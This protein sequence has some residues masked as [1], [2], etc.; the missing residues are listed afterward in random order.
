MN[1]YFFFCYDILAKLGNQLVPRSFT[2][3]ARCDENGDI[4]VGITFAYFIQ[5]KR[6][7]DL[8]GN[9]TRMV[10]GD[11]HYIFFAACKLTKSGRAD[12]GEHSSAHKFCFARLRRIMMYA[13]YENSVYALLVKAQLFI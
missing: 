10:A 4:G 13:R 1:Y 5:H 6:N 11:K 8:A 3:T 12:R 2:V 9:G 7:N